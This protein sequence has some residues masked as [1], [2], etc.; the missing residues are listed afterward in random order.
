LELAVV[1]AQ[2]L[3]W[4]LAQGWSLELVLVLAVGRNPKQEWALA[5]G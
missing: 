5:Q 3:Q 1:R 2:E 4:A